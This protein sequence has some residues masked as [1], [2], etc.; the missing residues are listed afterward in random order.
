MTLIASEPLFAIMNP[1]VFNDYFRVAAWAGWHC[2]LG[3][4][5][6]KLILD[7]YFYR[8]TDLVIRKCPIA[9]LAFKTRLATT[10]TVTVPFKSLNNAI[11]QPILSANANNYVEIDQ[12]RR[13]GAI[14]YLAP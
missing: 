11:A 12:Y 6:S 7:H 5:R 10:F 8:T 4:L 2:S 3:Y 9:V 13:T 14:E 1:T